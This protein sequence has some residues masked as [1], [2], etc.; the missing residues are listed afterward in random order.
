MAQ[1]LIYKNAYAYE[2]AMLILYGRHYFSRYRVI[3]D[4]IPSGASVLDVCCGP[5]LLYERFLKTK[6]VRYVGLDL[7]ERFIK[8]LNRRG[9]L[10]EVWDVRRETPLPCADYVIMQASLY[11]FLPDASSVFERMLAAAR[12]Q[13]IIAEPIRNLTQSK[14]RFF[15]SLSEVLTD[16]GVGRQPLRFTEQSLDRFFASYGTLP[17]QSFL[18]HGGRE[19]VY[20]CSKS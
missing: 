10:G 13:V 5:A 11:H 1:S 20:V 6:S 17:Q 4:L 8:R 12:K 19:K 9:G 18:V 3:A 16:P 7:N 2:L 15:A 14:M